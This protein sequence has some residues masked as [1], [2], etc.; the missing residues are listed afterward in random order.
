MC[1][2]SWGFPMKN[3]V[4]STKFFMPLYVL[5]AHEGLIRIKLIRLENPKNTKNMHLEAIDIHPQGIVVHLKVHNFVK[6]FR[7]FSKNEENQY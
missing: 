3:V 7:M 1:T 4:S 5:K 2:G 6:V